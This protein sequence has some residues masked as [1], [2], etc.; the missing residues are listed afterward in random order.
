MAGQGNKV[1]SSDYNTI[2]SIISPILGTSSGTT[3]YA[4]TVLSSQSSVNQKISAGQ[5]QNLYSDLIAARTHQTGLNETSN[6]TYPTTSLKITEA[7][8]AAYLA[9]ANTISANKLVTP[10]S[11][12]ATFETYASSSRNS[13]WNG[14][15]THTVSLTFDTAAYARGYFNAGGYIQFSASLSPDSPNLKNTSWQTMLTNMGTITWRYNG[16]TNSGNNTGTTTTSIGYNNLNTGFQTIFTKLTEQATYSPNQYDIYAAVN[17]GGNVI[18]FSIQFQDLSTTSNTTVYNTGYGN[19][20]PYGIDENITGT[21]LS[22][23]QG[24]RPSGSSVSIPYPAVS[25]SGP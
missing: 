13:A 9:Y 14:T 3:G 19:Y 18:Y 2:Q 21:L 20:G 24:Y 11:G 10:P 25:Q 23:V 8:R 5:W 16:T 12:Q 22:T 4:Q 7:D 1:L 6:L 17:A 15:I